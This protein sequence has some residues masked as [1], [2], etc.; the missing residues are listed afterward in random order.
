MR[1]LTALGSLLLPTV[2]SGFLGLPNLTGSSRT[3]RTFIIARGNRKEG[4]APNVGNG[5][6]DGFNVD[7]SKLAAL[8]GVLNQIERSYGRGSIVKLVDADHMIV[9]SIGTGALTLGQF[10]SLNPRS[11][12][13]A[14]Y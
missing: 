5:I 11:Y 13:T 3:R 7:P 6:S 8:D 4:P 2:S 10:V 12:E 14:I 9:D 1:Q